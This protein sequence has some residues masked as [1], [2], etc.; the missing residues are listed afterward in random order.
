MTRPI[1]RRPDPQ[2]RRWFGTPRQ[3]R[4]VTGLLLG[5]VIPWARADDAPLAVADLAAYRRALIARDAEPAPALIRF[6]EL[7]DHPA[8]YEGAR[9]QVEGRIVRRFRQGAFGTFPPLVEAWAVTASGDP[10]CWVYP[11]PNPK[12]ESPTV[13]E[14]VRFVG[15]FL[16]RIRY[17]GAD[18]ERLA[19]LIVGPRP[20]ASPPRTA[21]PP[22]LRSGNAV[23][24]WIL[25]IAG[26]AVVIAVL[27]WQHLR[28]P[29]SRTTSFEPGPAPQFDSPLS[30]A[31]VPDRD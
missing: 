25:G 18:V 7:W 21:R 13:R 3:A 6:R 4:L 26:A 27:A 28:K 19:P 11:A 30:E 1:A 8:R 20:P 14:N 22:V 16:K 23:N 29:V 2:R 12:A 15:T 9:V 10:F 17:Q 31:P 5:S 24:D